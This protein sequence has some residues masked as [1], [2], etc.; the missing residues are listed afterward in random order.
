MNRTKSVK[1]FM[2]NGI[3]I[4]KALCTLRTNF[5][6]SYNLNKAQVEVLYIIDSHNVIQMKEIA[7]LV[8]TTNGAVTQLI[9]GLVDMDYIERVYDDSD[10]RMICLKLS[11]EGA[12]KF[13]TFS[14]HHLEHVKNSLSQLNDMELTQLIQMQTKILNQLDLLSKFN[15]EN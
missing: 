4:Q 2:N 3:L 15:T 13:K 5:F 10:R 14:Q 6:K 7:R 1:A 12:K 9:Q 8:N 11:K